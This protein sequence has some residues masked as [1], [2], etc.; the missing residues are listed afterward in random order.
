[1]NLDNLSKKEIQEKLSELS[2]ELQRREEQQASLDALEAAGASF[3]A[4]V[5]AAVDAGVGAANALIHDNLPQTYI[6]WVATAGVEIVKNIPRFIQ[7]NPDAT[8]Y[9]TGQQVI[10]QGAVYTSVID[11][12]VFSPMAYPQGWEKA[13]GAL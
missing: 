8:G 7:P 11:N 5:Q 9:M 4:A 10:F 2:A 12:N 13:K 1:M 3:L 6:D